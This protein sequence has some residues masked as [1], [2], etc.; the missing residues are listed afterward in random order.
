MAALALALSAF[1]LVRV[2]T[3]QGVPDA[4]MPLAETR[5]VPAADVPGAE[6]A[7]LPRYPGSVRVEYDHAVASGLATTRV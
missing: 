6:L 4:D 3:G 1:A 5:S 2:V 7:G